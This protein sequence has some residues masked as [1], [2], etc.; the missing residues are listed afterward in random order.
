LYFPTKDLDI[1]SS[2]H[3]LQLCPCVDLVRCQVLLVDRWRRLADQRRKKCQSR[4]LVFE[5][6]YSEETRWVEGEVVEIRPTFRIRSVIADNSTV[7]RRA[8]KTSFNS[9]G[10]QQ[11]VDR[12]GGRSQTRHRAKMTRAVNT[13]SSWSFDSLC[14]RLR[15]GSWSKR[16]H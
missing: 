12:E 4:V 15:D 3:S 10:G 2:C 8:G 5:T 16:P 14:K 1:V 9:H 11:D 7:I 6:T 13:L